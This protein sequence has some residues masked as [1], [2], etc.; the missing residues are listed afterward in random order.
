MIPGSFLDAVPYYCIFPCSDPKCKA[1]EIFF[2]STAGVVKCFIAKMDTDDVD[3][4]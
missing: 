1:C 2:V 3:A 4:G